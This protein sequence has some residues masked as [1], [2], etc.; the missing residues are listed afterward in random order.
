MLSREDNEL[1]TR[2]GPGTPMGTLWR[3]FW[4]P[5]LVASELSEP[6]G[7]PVRV[8]I[9]GEE[10]VA[11][12]DSQNRIGF[13]EEYCPHRLASLYFG[14]NEG[15]GLRCVYHGWQWDVHGNCL[16]M[17][18]E[19]P[20]CEFKQKVKARAYP[21]KEWGGLVWI[22]MGPKELEPELPM[23]EWCLV[24]DSH[25]HFTKLSQACNYA[26]ALDGEMDPSHLAFLHG[27]LDIPDDKS[28]ARLIRSPAK[29]TAKHTNYGVIC[30][31]R[32]DVSE[33]E[34]YW[35][36]THYL[37]PCFSLT[38]TLTMSN[39]LSFPRSGRCWVPMDDEHAWCFDYLFHP[40][41][42]LTAAQVANNRDN[43]STA[44][45]TAK[46]LANKDNDYLIDRE[47]Q[48]TENFSGLKGTR[49]QDMAVTESMG[50]IC[51]RTRE[52]L[53]PAD[54]A[55][56]KMRSCLLRHARQLG[57]GVEPVAARCADLYRI[58]ALH[59]MS[60]VAEFDA[61]IAAHIGE[62]TRGRGLESIAFDAVPRAAQGSDSK[63]RDRG[64]CADV[65]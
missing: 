26:Q 10:L 4:L 22:Y 55:M 24:P 19:A 8:K 54:A 28:P 45:G 41:Q 33:G 6:G 65:D 48:R 61:F 63:R 64:E 31:A 57:A 3:R 56:I 46:A 62:L 50:P 60:P 40:D 35:R 30:G 7:P 32:R 38:V 17:P 37:V 39:A 52:H 23:L 59:S 12:R 47:M 58:R 44:S 51:D 53:A 20:D 9:L 29:I 42:P 34:Y 27:K 36:I 14:R 16:D 25:R 13:L 49:V 18:T 11:F 15:G 1:L 5:A 21:G 2:T 43:L